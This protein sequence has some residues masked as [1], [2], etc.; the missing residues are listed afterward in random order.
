L[1]ANDLSLACQIWQNPIHIA[2]LS[3]ILVKLDPPLRLWALEFRD[4]IALNRERRAC[5]DMHWKLRLQFN[6]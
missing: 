4:R 3:N 2:D 6:H 1:S 5:F